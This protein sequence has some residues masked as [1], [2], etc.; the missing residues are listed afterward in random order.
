[1]IAIDIGGNIG[2]YAAEIRRRS[3]QVE[4]HTFEP[5]AANIRILNQRFS[6]DTNIKILPLAV[7]DRTGWT[8][9][10]SNKAGSALGSLTQRRLEH[11]N[12]DFNVRETINSIRFEDYWRNHLN[13]RVLD[14]VKMDIEGHEFAAL[15]GFGEAIFSTCVLQFE[16]GG[17]NIDSRTYFQDF[18]YFFKEHHFDIYIIA[19]AGP[20]MINNYA[21]SEECFLTANYVAVNR[22]TPKINAA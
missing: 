14:I 12:I 10:F 15:I 11:H 9:L 4:I 22:K 13:S 7:S 2:N 1:L 21:E 6:D 16:F 17:T 19:P 5:S 20:Y 18:W 3:P 8:T